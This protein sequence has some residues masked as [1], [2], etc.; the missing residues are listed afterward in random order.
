[1]KTCYALCGAALC[2]EMASAENV[3]VLNLLKGPTED[4]CEK[5]QKA[6]VHWCDALAE[7][8]RTHA[9]EGTIKIAGDDVVIAQRECD[10][11]CPRPCGKCKTTKLRKTPSK[12]NTPRPGANAE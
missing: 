1:M 3:K 11:A 4:P 12:R 2:D 6:L 7:K 5:A 8:K 10:E 9:T